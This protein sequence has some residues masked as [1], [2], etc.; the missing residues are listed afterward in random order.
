MPAPPCTAQC[1]P[2]GSWDLPGCLPTGCC[3][4]GV[5]SHPQHPLRRGSSAP[6]WPSQIG[7]GAGDPT[8]VPHPARGGGLQKDGGVRAWPHSQLLFLAGGQAP[9]SHDRVGLG[10]AKYTA[11]SKC[12]ASPG[13]GHAPGQRWPPPGLVQG[14]VCPLCPPPRAGG[15]CL[16]GTDQKKP[17]LV[18]PNP[19]PA[20]PCSGV[21]VTA[22][23]SCHCLFGRAGSCGGSATSRVPQGGWGC[24]SST[25]GVLGVLLCQES[26]P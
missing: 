19:A 14:A 13:W 10:M 8:L 12:R 18:L 15:V 2:G 7:A 22:C 3:S 21:R 24:V 25:L 20:C 26:P 4:W 5:P 16:D 1:V 6:V 11:L 17:S 9:S 23:R